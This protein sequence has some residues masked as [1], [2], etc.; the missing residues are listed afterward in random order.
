MFFNI[1]Y[2][3]DITLVVIRNTS[4]QNYTF[5][6]QKGSLQ[7]YDVLVGSPGVLVLKRLSAP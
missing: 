1:S 6:A 5:F 7:L 3:C 2:V 4:K